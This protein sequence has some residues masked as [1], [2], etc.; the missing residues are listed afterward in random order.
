[1]ISAPSASAPTI[2]E[3]SVQSTDGNLP[4]VFALDADYPN[5]FNPTTTIPIS[6]PKAAHVKVQVYNVA[7]LVAIL[8][9]KD[10]QAGRYQLR[11]DAHTLASGMYLVRAHLG[12]K[13]FTRK[14][15]LIK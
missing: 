2:A 12:G 15:T 10:Y 14:L 4:K 9:N 6:L 7:G 8:T 11:F 1:M 5:P 13:V 3:K